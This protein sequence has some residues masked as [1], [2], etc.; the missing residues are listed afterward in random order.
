M[1]YN[2]IDAVSVCFQFCVELKLIRRVSL[3]YF[4]NTNNNDPNN[5]NHQRSCWLQ[6]RVET[7][8]G[9]HLCPV[10]HRVPWFQDRMESQD[11]RTPG[12][13]SGQ[14]EPTI[15]LEKG[16]DQNRQKI[17]APPAGLE[18]A[19]CRLTAWRSTNWAMEE[20]TTLFRNVIFKP[21]RYLCLSFAFLR[22]FLEHEKIR[23]CLLAELHHTL[24]CTR[25]EFK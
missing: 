11:V 10:I 24:K 9:G 1:S 3:V 12:E 13:T 25:F 14:V 2:L 19:T 15:I 5:Y 18:P 7:H 4:N 6:E 21:W 8:R 16:I 22:H 17:I 20:Y 23:T